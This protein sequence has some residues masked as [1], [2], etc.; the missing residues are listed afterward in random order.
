M[1]KILVADD[2]RFII[3]TVKRILEP[4]YLVYSVRN[5]T[6]CIKFLL[7]TKVDLILL[8]ISMP[9]MNGIEAMQ[10]IHSNENIKNIPIIFLTGI[11]DEEM[12]QTCLRLGAKDFIRKPY[13]E[14]ILR[15][16]INT[17]LKMDELQKDLSYQVKIKT[18][19]LQKLTL[20]TIITF[21]NAIDA[22]DSYTQ[23]H[24]Y[25]VARYTEQIA[26]RMG[27]NEA[28]ICNLFYAALL[29]DIGKIGIP[30][31]ILTK[32][33]KLTPW[34]YA[35]VQSHAVIGEKILKDITVIPILN[36]GAR[37]HHER[38]DGK[39]Y[40]NGTVG[41]EI[42]I[43]GRIIQIADSIDAMVAGRVYRKAIPVNEV[44]NELR[45]NSGTQYDPKCVEIACDMLSEGIVFTSEEKMN[46]DVSELL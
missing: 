13:N 5:G 28:E 3:E 22:K 12:E 18:A 6:D 11:A 1:K 2:S 35:I 4:Y 44:I 29:H 10:F 40:P 33:G 20:Q 25:H 19:E 21:A 41:E 36:V 14:I 46:F 24:S 23:R 31:Q 30:D 32:P 26:Y 27:W 17:V 43:V 15:L 16:R 42:P 34:E 9:Q 38:Y 37:Y 7:D 8:D 45:L 39:G